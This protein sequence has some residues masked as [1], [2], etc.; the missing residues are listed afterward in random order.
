MSV[1][2][3]RSFDDARSRSHGDT[4]AA[5]VCDKRAAAMSDEAA[6][7]TSLLRRMASGDEEAL[8]SLYDA[9]SSRVYGAVLKTVADAGSA[10]EVTHDAYMQAWRNAAE[11]DDTRGSPMAWLLMMARSR[12]LDRVRRDRLRVQHEALSDHPDA[13]SDVSTT[14]VEQQDFQR[15]RRVRKALAAL[16]IE[17]QRA[18]LLAY[19]GG[20]THSEI[21]AE[22][23]LPLGTVK[24]QIRAGVLR[25]RDALEELNPW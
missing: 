19:Y 8:T 17:Q 10:E 22:L 21:A 14:V 9:T 11:F 15:T 20:R 23:N 24:S 16:P 12:A 18:L 7:L 25:L 4:S 6:T 5:A 1:V 2:P 3:L 13:L